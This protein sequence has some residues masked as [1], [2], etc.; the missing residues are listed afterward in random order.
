MKKSALVFLVFLFIFP[1]VAN[2]QEYYHPYYQE[3]PLA[4][5]GVPAYPYFLENRTGAPLTVY[6]YVDKVRWEFAISPDHEVSGAMLP[7][8]AKIK[9]EAFADVGKNK[10]RN[11]QKVFS[12]FY[13]REEHNGKISRGW[14]LYR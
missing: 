4:N 13:H 6:L 3:Q 2:A 5:S 9:V 10:G 14:V 7:L 12:A 8:G 11:K 1:L